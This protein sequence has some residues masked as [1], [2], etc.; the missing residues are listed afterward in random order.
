MKI[1]GP[2]L[3]RNGT[4][5]PSDIRCPLCGARNECAMAQT[6]GSTD[7]ACWCTQVEIDRKALARIPRDRIGQACLCP[8]CASGL[9]EGEGV[10]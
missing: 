10:P 7:V 3:R 1:C 8:R 6:A 9:A 2:A 5:N 4:A